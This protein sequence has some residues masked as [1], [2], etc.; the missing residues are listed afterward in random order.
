LEADGT[1]REQTE[2]NGAPHDQS[3]RLDMFIRKHPVKK[4]KEK[5]AL[6]RG[7]I[8]DARAMQITL[9]ADQKLG[10]QAA[11]PQLDPEK[12]RAALLVPLLGLGQQIVGNRQPEHPLHGACLQGPFQI[13]LQ[14]ILFLFTQLIDNKLTHDM[15]SGFFGKFMMLCS[16]MR[17]DSSHATWHIVTVPEPLPTVTKE[18]GLPMFRSVSFTFDR[19]QTGQ[20]P[21]TGYFLQN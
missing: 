14:I 16:A 6:G 1:P 21:A 15:P 5:L 12:K 18:T 13:R 10:D 2:K 4:T 3:L 8:T 7:G 19:T 20:Y 9:A 11:A 17:R